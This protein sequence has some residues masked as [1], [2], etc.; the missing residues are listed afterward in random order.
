MIIGVDI[1]GTIVIHSS[2]P[3]YDYPASLLVTGHPNTRAITELYNAHRRGHRVVYITG[4]PSKARPI[5]LW[6]LGKH[7]LPLGPV[8]TQATWQGWQ[9]LEDYKTQALHDNLVDI[10]IGNEDTDE[11][12]ATRAGCQ[13]LHV[14]DIR[15]LNSLLQAHERAPTTGPTKNTSGPAIPPTRSV[16]CTPGPRPPH[17]SPTEDA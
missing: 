10:Y 3:D 7:G 14:R 4:R 8:I 9:A 1:D 15:Q 6:Q 11:N 12:A 16:P 13:F 17:P 5:T 2:N